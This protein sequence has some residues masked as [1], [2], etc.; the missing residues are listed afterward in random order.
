MAVQLAN[1][2]TDTG[3]GYVDWG[4]IL[5]GAMVATAL[6]VVLFAFGAAL[7]LSVMSP[8]AGEGLPRA[9]YFAAIGLWT[10]WVVVSSFMAG[11]YIAGRLR[12]R[13]GDATDQEADVRD[14]AHG[15][16]VWA[17]GVVAAAL[18]LAAGVT[19]AAGAAAKLG[20]AAARADGEGMIAYTVDGLFRG[21]APE[22]IAEPAT[23]RSE[24][25]RLLVYGMADG[26][27]ETRDRSYIARLIADRTAISQADAEARVD[28]AT[29]RIRQAA[30]SAR[31]IGVLA[32]F[33]TVA[34]LAVGAAAS[35]WAATLGGRHRDR[36]IDARVFWH[37]A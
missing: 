25:A 14:G 30:D 17:T 28:Q 33:L 31:R 21:A 37:W 32:G 20:E 18:L 23:D 13:I 35:A 34:G 36:N 8:Y 27:L 1:A 15:L 3:A 9:A 26:D 24:V 10:L 6:S 5:A 12:R 22:R 11:G 7:G 29:A 16:L 2:S 4:A 19:G